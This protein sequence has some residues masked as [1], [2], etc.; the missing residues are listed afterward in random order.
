MSHF[1]FF[2]TSLLLPSNTPPLLPQVH[3]VLALPLLFVLSAQTYPAKNDK[4]LPRSDLHPTTNTI[5]LNVSCIIITRRDHGSTITPRTRDFPWINNICG[6]SLSPYKHWSCRFYLSLDSTKCT[7]LY[8]ERHA[9]NVQAYEY[10]KEWGRPRPTNTPICVN[11]CSGILSPRSRA[12]HLPMDPFPHHP[13][14]SRL[15]PLYSLSLP[16]FL[17]AQLPPADWQAHR[18]RSALSH[19]T[20]TRFLAHLRFHSFTKHLVLL[21]FLL[22]HAIHLQCCVCPNYH[23]CFAFPSFQFLELWKM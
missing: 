14:F 17:S 7:R 21:C 16:L 5:Y 9:V 2:Q 12:L 15:F 11:I 22:A 3:F 1:Y 6:P 18:I 8:R 10:I 20:G 13:P 23:W 4:L 19:Q